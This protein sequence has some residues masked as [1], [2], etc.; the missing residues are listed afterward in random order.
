MAQR[1]LNCLFLPKLAFMMLSILALSTAAAEDDA[2]LLQQQAIARIDA[3]V[4]HF[5]KT[6]DFQS[7]IIDLQQ[8]EKELTA[9]NRTFTARG[10]WS[11]VAHGWVRLGQI[12]RMQA[13]WELALAYYRQ[14]VTV[15][16]R[17]DAAAIHARALIG[18]AQTEAQRRDYGSAAVHA[19]RA[20]KLSEPLTDRKLLFDA[21]SVA[22]QIQINQGNLN[23]AVDM[24]NR[25]FVAAREANDEPSLFYSHLDRADIYFKFA[26]ECDY[27]RTYEICF[28]AIERARADYQ[29]ALNLA[30]KLDYA[31]LAKATEGFLGNLRRQE[32]LVQEQRGLDRTL[33]QTTIFNPKKPGDVLVTEEFVVT[34]TFPPGFEAL[35]RQFE[36]WTQ[37]LSPFISSLSTLYM[38]GMRQ[39][40]QG[41]HAAALKSFLQAVDL[42]ERD[43]G[44]LRDDRNRGSFLEDK[45]HIYY[46]AILQL[47]HHRRY[48][49]AFALLERSRSR[50]MADLLASRPPDFVRPEERR[51]YGETIKL[52]SEIAALQS[53]L[54]ALISEEDPKARAK[55]VTR[56]AQIAQLENQ[57]QSVVARMTKEAPRVGELLVSEPVSLAR[58]QQSMWRENYEVLQ[59][60]VLDHGI[61]LWHISADAV[62]VVHVFLPRIQVME[63]V[64]KLRNSLDDG[65]TPF[66]EETARQL[67]LFLIQPAK[68]WLKSDHLV[69]IPHED[70]HHVPFQVLQDPADGHFLGERHALSYAPSATVLLGLK[71]GASVIEGKLLAIADPSIEAAREEV[72]VIATLYPQR[73]KVVKDPLAREAE[74]KAW[75]G[76]YDLVHLAVHGKFET[77]EP[78]LSYLKLSDGGQD[79]GQLTAAEMFGLP[80][81]RARLVVLSACETG[82]AEVTHGNEVLGMMRAL[83]YAGAGALVL[84]YW[85]VESEATALW[86]KTFYRA[87]QSMPPAEAARQALQAVKSQPEY[88]HPYFWAAFM[89]VGR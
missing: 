43:R 47:L 76:D 70:L 1:D 46:Y 73:A 80:L 40:S 69:I 24:L 59:Y 15:A 34:G 53:T 45:I 25:A 41:D 49:D 20:I 9:S 32:Q 14:A 61:I 54:P 66:A 58:L 37:P 89:T 78:L 71:K 52:K 79:D 10:D 74:V 39:Q 29:T 57:Y 44:K 3:F 22:G 4:E 8:A 28:A 62:H 55:V 68:Q 65:H 27:Q 38:T 75:V 17:A 67:F 56:S 60:L 13:D 31:G 86:M 30:R 26:R 6:G 16:E 7:R 50:V 19:A 72:E 5:R 82:R 18:L 36:Q 11:A 77:T 83:I 2:I 12:Q 81:D 35:Y 85:P 21:L 23:A 42:L 84:S 88:K 48:A 51:L 63:K 33:S 64:A 87:V